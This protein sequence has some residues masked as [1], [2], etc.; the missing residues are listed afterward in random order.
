LGC[1]VGQ[2]LGRS[3]IPDG[4]GQSTRLPDH[5]DECFVKQLFVLMEFLAGFIQADL[6][7]RGIIG[8]LID[9]QDVFQ[10]GDERG[11]RLGDAPRFYLPRLDRVFF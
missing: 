4:N 11:R 1:Q 3:D 2:P 7:A 9:V 8:T 10:L 5:H 6:G